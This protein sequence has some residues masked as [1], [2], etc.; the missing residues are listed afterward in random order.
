MPWVKSHRLLSEVVSSRMPTISIE[1]VQA[2]TASNTHIRV[3]KAKMAISRCSM[4]VS[5]STP[6][7]EIGSN[8][9]VRPLMMAMPTLMLRETVRSSARRFAFFKSW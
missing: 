6:K 3:A 1:V 5:P 4:T 7:K 9:K 2:G 8:H